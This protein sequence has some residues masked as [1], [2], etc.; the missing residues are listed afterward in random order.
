[1]LVLTRKN[2]E[3]VIVGENIVIRVLE[4]RDGRVKLGIEA[5]RDVT[6]HRSEVKARLAA[7]AKVNAA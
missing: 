5:P 3:D 4:A 1:M 6:V 2:G 7:E